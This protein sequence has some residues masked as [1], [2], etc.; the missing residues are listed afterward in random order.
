MKKAEDA[1][2][3]VVGADVILESSVGM[4]YDVYN[5]SRLRSRFGFL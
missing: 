2:N 5:P 4:E 1:K 3:A